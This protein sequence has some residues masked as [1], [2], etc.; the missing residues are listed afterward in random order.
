[1]NRI[2]FVILAFLTF[3]SSILL[4]TNLDRSLLWQDEG[5]T[6]CVAKT[7]LEHGVPMGYD[8][9]NSFSQQN[10]RELS[11]TG[12]WKLH[13]WFQFYWLAPF[14][15][16]MNHDTFTARFPFVVLGIAS[17]LL[18]FTFFKRLNHSNK[19]ALFAALI[20]MLSEFF[21]LSTRQARYYSPVHFF[22]L[23]GLIGVVPLLSNKEHSLKS[24]ATVAIGILGLFVSHYLF[25]ITFIG[26]CVTYLLIKKDKHSL[27]KL[28]I[29]ILLTLIMCLPYVYWLM[30]T[31]YGSNFFD[32]LSINT[33][34]DKLLQFGKYTLTY[35]FHIVWIGPLV[36][37]LFK[38]NHVKKDHVN[39]ILFSS[40]LIILNWLALSILSKEFS[41]R[42]TSGLIV[43]SALIISVIFIQAYDSK[44]LVFV[45]MIPLFLWQNNT[46]NYVRYEL[47]SEYN[48]PV[49][50]M[51]F[52]LQN[53]A[54]SNDTI[55]IP[56]GDLPVKYYLPD[57]KIIS[58]YD[59]RLVQSE[60]L[61]YSFAFPR[62]YPMNQ[63]DYDLSNHIL[64][65]I[66]GKKR[67]SFN[68]C[69]RTVENMPRPDLH[70]YESNKSEK[71]E[72]LTVVISK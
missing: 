27:K 70:T 63:A 12:I 18:M 45:I 60:E 19:E 2:Q 8:S 46:F 31:P 71:C 22:T 58:S 29:P 20:L 33:L 52:F 38:R 21:L 55:L 4:L 62:F 37:I 16:V 56:Y 51:T 11:E 35:V 9:I 59:G 42:Y 69:D 68:I 34:T 23:L 65:T 24:Q 17:V 44:R 7:I 30:D 40:V 14:L 72:K 53:E 49:R 66:E 10:G 5:E 61:K 25:A 67:I 6:A 3:L 15:A 32:T 43:F 13:P 54:T 26:A 57:L 48:G 64:K 1:V 39:L 41:P 47:L 50:G 36:W 28:S